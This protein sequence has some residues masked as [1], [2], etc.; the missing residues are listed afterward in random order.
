MHT[1]RGEGRAQE[2]G[3]GKGKIYTERGMFT[4][5]ESTKGE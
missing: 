4:V 5:R 1:E 3:M 2:G